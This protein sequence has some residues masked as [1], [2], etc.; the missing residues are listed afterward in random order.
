MSTNL[1]LEYEYYNEE[2]KRCFLCN[3]WIETSVKRIKYNNT[4][5][6]YHLT[7]FCKIS[8]NPNY[9]SINYSTTKNIY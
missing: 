4:I 9:K 8:K 3:D 6:Y 5:Y 1:A 7:C 2:I